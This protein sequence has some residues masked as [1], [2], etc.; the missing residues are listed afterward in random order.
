MALLSQPT[1]KRVK[2]YPSNRGKNWKLALIWFKI[3]KNRIILFKLSNFLFS[4]ISE[5]I[6][7]KQEN[8][9]YFH[10][11]HLVPPTLVGLAMAIQNK[12]KLEA[13]NIRHIYKRCLKG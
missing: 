7:A 9:E 2:L 6:Y 4:V 5:L 13:K 8:E 3:E 10:P 11:L 12:Y 1:P